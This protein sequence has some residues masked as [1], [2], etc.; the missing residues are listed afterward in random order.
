M[1]TTINR[2]FPIINGDLLPEPFAASEIENPEGEEGKG[3][4]NKKNVCHAEL[5][6]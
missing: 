4:K 1:A 5:H 3:G 6:S 2:I